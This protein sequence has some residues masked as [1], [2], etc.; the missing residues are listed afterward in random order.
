MP[1]LSTQP[2][3]EYRADAISAGE[4]WRLLSGH[5]IHLN[6]FHLV[7]NLTGLMIFFLISYK[8]GF[9][10]FLLKVLYLAFGIGLLLWW[11]TPEI[12]SYVGF[13]GVLYALLFFSLWQA[14]NETG[15]V[16]ILVGI[17]L[18]VMWQW[19][20]GPAQYEEA[21]IGGKIVAIAH[22]Y[23]ILLAAVWMGVIAFFRY[24]KR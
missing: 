12:E 16:L 10:Q 7:L 22:V 20:V 21:L 15:N 14:R 8:N 17:L 5:F 3:L 9:C 4:Y 11:F 19:L 18:W 1:F 6:G 23:G 24:F 13:S 2:L